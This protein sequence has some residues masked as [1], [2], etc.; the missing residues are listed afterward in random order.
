MSEFMYHISIYDRVNV[1]APFKI[2]M[3]R[4]IRVEILYHSTLISQNNT[5]ISG[6]LD[7]VCKYGARGK[8]CT[9]SFQSYNSLLFLL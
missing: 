6:S 2:V 3:I 5:P 8:S 1:L 4:D 7:R 9:T